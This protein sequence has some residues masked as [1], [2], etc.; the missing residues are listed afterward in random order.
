MQDFMNKEWMDDYEKNYSMYK[1]DWDSHYEQIRNFI[2][3]SLP[4]KVSHWGFVG[5]T[6]TIPEID[7]RILHRISKITLLDINDEALKRAR[8]HLA[9][10]FD[11]HHVEVQKF[12]NTSGFV[13]KIADGFRHFNNKELSEKKLLEFLNGLEINESVDIPNSKQ[14]NKKYDFITH[15]GIMDYYLMPLFTKY[16][17]NFQK[18]LDEFF[19]IMRKLNDYSVRISL[20]LLHSMLEKNGLLIISTPV[21]RIPEGEICKRSIFWLD[22]I[23][24]IIED[25]DFS[26]KYKTEHMWNEFPIEG[27]HSHIVVNICCEKQS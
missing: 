27:G 7:S 26:I 8:I 25:C 18:N 3:S 15:L 9:S 20:K 22:T 13:D 6:N 4:H 21:S 2:H 16:C 12:D 10:V 1:S 5:V 17:S 24:S 11:F 14:N 23:E 19:Q